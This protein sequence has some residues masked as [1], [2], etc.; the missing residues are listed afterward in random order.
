MICVIFFIPNKNKEK[1]KKKTTL[2]FKSKYYIA[3][4][5]VLETLKSLEYKVI[6]E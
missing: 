3:V 5:N 1:I 4:L 6:F 2:W